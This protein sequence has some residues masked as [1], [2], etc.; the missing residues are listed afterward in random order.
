MQF[1]G[2]DSETIITISDQRSHVRNFLIHGIVHV[3]LGLRIA[4]AALFYGGGLA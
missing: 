4:L 1:C 2:P 3:T